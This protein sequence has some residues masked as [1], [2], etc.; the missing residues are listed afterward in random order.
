MYF[1]MNKKLGIVLPIMYS[2]EGAGEFDFKGKLRSSILE[3]LYF[4]LV[5]MLF[6][7]LVLIKF[8]LYGEFEL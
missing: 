2:Y 6:F 4:Y 3:N 1:F 7:G 8:V 5:V